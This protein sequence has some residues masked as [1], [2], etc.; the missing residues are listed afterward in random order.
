MKTRPICLKSRSS[1]SL[2]HGLPGGKVEHY[3][4]EEIQQDQGGKIEKNEGGELIS[5]NFL[6]FETTRLICE[7]IFFFGFRLRNKIHRSPFTFS[8]GLVHRLQGFP[9]L[10][11]WK[12]VW[13][14]WTSVLLTWGWKGLVAQSRG[15]LE[16]AE[17]DDFCFKLLA[18]YISKGLCKYCS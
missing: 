5:V 1:Q 2:P 15:C 17:N 11:M 8:Y 4:I 9:I 13:S 14:T 16:G 7:T 6:V 10:P 3:R 12:A 18:L